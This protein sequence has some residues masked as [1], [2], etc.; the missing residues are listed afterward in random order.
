MEDLWNGKGWEMILGW[1]KEIPE[2]M[3]KVAVFGAAGQVGRAVMRSLL[4]SDEHWYLRHAF[5]KTPMMPPSPPCHYNQLES[6]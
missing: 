5:C 3:S 1:N 6:N 4:R 2:V